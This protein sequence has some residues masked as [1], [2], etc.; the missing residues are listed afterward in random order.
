VCVG[1]VFSTA[2]LQSSLQPQMPRFLVENNGKHTA[3]GQQTQNVHSTWDIFTVNI[4]D[5][6]LYVPFN[7]VT[8]VWLGNEDG[9]AKERELPSG[10]KALSRRLLQA[11]HDV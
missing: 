3:C 5:S 7:K 1:V 10:T 4:I 11:F 6:S 8:K 2:F 9:S